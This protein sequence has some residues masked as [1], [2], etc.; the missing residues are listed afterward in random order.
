MTKHPTPASP[1]ALLG[2]IRALIEEARTHV[3]RAANSA[4]ALTYWRVGRRI[5][6]EILGGERASYGSQIV[7]SLA[8]RL[9]L[10]YGQGF[11]VQN[12]RRMV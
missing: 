3:A 6:S 8:R 4:L 2:D 9:G 10:E 5:D 12:L 7:V 1:D 11:G